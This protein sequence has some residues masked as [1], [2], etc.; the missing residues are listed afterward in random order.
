[1]LGNC[2][3]FSCALVKCR[4]FSV[5]FH[6]TVIYALVLEGFEE[7]VCVCVEVALQ[8]TRTNVM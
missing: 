7:A 3:I 6:E 2:G 4:C 5:S 1:M 8:P